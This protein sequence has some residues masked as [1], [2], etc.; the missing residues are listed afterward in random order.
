MLKA[1]YCKTTCILCLWR[2]TDY[3]RYKLVLSSWPIYTCT[4]SP[5]ITGY[6]RSHGILISLYNFTWQPSNYHFRGITHYQ[7][8][9]I[10]T[11]PTSAPST[12]L[13]GSNKTTTIISIQQCTVGNCYMRIRAEL[14][15]GSVT[16]YSPCVPINSQLLVVESKYYYTTM[17]VEVN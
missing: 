8:Q 6:S 16:D 11:C 14:S 17:H 9:F 5:T 1:G 7:F 15:D 13:T 3:C 10:E 2:Y 12:L 4:R